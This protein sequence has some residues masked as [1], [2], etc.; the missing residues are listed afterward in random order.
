M[1]VRLSLKWKQLAAVVRKVD[2]VIHRINHYPLDK[3]I[4][5]PNTY[6]LDSDLT[7]G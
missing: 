5:F 7:G 6:V 4:G 1:K 2:S 3:A